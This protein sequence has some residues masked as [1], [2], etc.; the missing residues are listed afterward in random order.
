MITEIV[1]LYLLKKEKEEALKN[2]INNH[3]L[4]EYLKMEKPKYEWHTPIK[5]LYLYLS[6]DKQQR[7][8][9]NCSFASFTFSK[10]NPMPEKNRE[11]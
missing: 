7:K 11:C 4:Q 9:F 1:D 10:Q 6:M 3:I 2:K 8:I 5:A